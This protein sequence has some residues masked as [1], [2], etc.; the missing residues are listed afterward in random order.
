MVSVDSGASPAF[1]LQSGALFPIAEGILTSMGPS[2]PTHIASL[3]SLLLESCH[4][5]SLCP[6]STATSFVQVTFFPP[7]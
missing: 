3:S 4:T 7:P 5:L 6:H 2:Q 1:L